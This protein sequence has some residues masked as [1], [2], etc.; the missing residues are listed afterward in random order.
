MPIIS[1]F[2]DVQW[3]IHRQQ[4]NNN[5]ADTTKN[6][7]L[8]MTG[9]KNH[10]VYC[11]STTTTVFA[12]TE[13]QHIHE[14][15]IPFLEQFDMVITFYPID[16]KTK[17]IYWRPL[18]P[19]FVGMK[20]NLNSKTWSP[21]SFYSYDSLSNYHN[22]NRISDKVCIITSSKVFTPG[23]QKRINLINYLKGRDNT[24]FDIYGIEDANVEDKM[25]VLSRYEFS[26]VIENSEIINYWTEKLL[27]AIIAE[28]VIYYIGCPN[29]GDYFQTKTIIPI[30]HLCFEEMY[31][32]I[33]NDL[34]NIKYKN[35][36]Q[37]LSKT[38]KRGLE[39]FN[40][41]Q[42]VIK[43]TKQAK[44]KNKQSFILN[45]RFFQSVSLAKIFKSFTC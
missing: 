27:D 44:T 42:E 38:K 1:I 45:E 33:K 40:I 11:N 18:L 43:F 15:S 28:N 39:E 10:L 34:Q 30:S 16:L 9:F 37:D 12:I 24:I 6:I 13:P 8:F 22:F 36:I 23:H 21:G 5:D 41:F 4:R 32:K 17:V 19:W 25:D 20:F 7:N 29:I 31:L 2:S 26:L 3:S 35:L 14:H